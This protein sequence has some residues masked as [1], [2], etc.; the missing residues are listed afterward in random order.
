MTDN[1]RNGAIMAVLGAMVL[2]AIA[3]GGSY[4]VGRAD[5]RQLEATTPGSTL[6][7]QQRFIEGCSAAATEADCQCMYGYLMDTYG[8]EGIELMAQDSRSDFT[9]RAATDAALNCA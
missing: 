2:I 4:S 6:T 1:Q 9:V 3:V 5:Q 7:E 8:R